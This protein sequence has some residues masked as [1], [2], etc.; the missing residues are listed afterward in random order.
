V[1]SRE[2]A[3]EFQAELRLRVDG[4]EQMSQLGEV[5]ETLLTEPL[6]CNCDRGAENSAPWMT[7]RSDECR[8]TA[9]GTS[10][11]EGVSR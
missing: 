3:C 8:S 9:P 1:L 4:T 2:E 10:G 7:K 5:D 6:C 11:D